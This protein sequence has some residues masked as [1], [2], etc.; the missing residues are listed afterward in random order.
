MTSHLYL[1]RS[2]ITVLQALDHSIQ[3][4]YAAPLSD[5][6]ATRVRAKDLC[7][8]RETLH[9]SCLDG[10]AITTGKN[11]R[12]SSRRSSKGVKILQGH[13]EIDKPFDGLCSLCP[14][15]LKA[16]RGRRLCRTNLWVGQRHR[17]KRVGSFRRR[18][19]CGLIPLASQ[20]AIPKVIIKTAK[21]GLPEQLGPVSEKFGR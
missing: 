8:S 20:R 7:F 17:K 12:Y 2:A 4:R 15:R 11:E 1:L 6:L 3:P 21:R 10:S 13:C 16:S 14:P 9:C 18:T 5:D 19:W